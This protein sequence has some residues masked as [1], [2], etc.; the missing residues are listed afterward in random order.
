MKLFTP[1]KYIKNYQFVDFDDLK[2]H[3]I[4]LI[5]CDVDNTLVAHDEKLPCDKVHTFKED[6]LAHGFKFCL[7]SNNVSERVSTF[8]NSLDVPFYPNAKK[9]LL[10]TYKKIMKEYKLQPNEICGIGD[11]LLTDVLGGNRANIYTILTHPLY[12]KDLI[13][14]KI[15]RSLENLVFS[16]LSSKKILTKGDYDE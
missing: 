12:T 5:I 4:K 1:N 11:Q 8:A 7:I 13:W 16:Y 3:G 15:N 2:K 10:I 6:A 9:P 14:T